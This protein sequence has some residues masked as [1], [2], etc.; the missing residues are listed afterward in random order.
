[1]LK[2]DYFFVFDVVSRTPGT[3]KIAKKGGV[4]YVLC[5]C[6]IGLMGKGSTVY[7]ISVNGEP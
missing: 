2:E 1:M 5:V 3:Q 7:A 4:L 6:G